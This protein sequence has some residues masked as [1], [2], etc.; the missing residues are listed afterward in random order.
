MQVVELFLLASLPSPLAFVLYASVS[1]RMSR[2]KFQRTVGK[3][4][5]L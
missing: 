3:C 5:I 1:M 4:Q 2:I